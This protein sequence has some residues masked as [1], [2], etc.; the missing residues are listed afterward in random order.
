MRLRKSL[1]TVTSPEHLGAYIDSRKGSVMG[2]YRQRINDDNIDYVEVTRG[3]FSRDQ[4]GSLVF[5]INEPQISGSRIVSEG[6][7]ASEAV[8]LVVLSR[9]EM[10]TPTHPNVA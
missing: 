5:E 10:P 2:E 3:A 9:R 6:D 8:G 1:H 7:F 4:D